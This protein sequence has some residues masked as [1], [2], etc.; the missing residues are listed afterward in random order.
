MSKRFKAI[1]VD[2]EQRAI[3]ILKH[4]LDEHEEI[5]IAGTAKKVDEAI[6][7]I[8]EHQ[9]DLVFL[10][11]KMPGKSGFE[12][13]HELT[14]LQLNTT[15]IFTTAY[16]QYGIEAIRHEAFD[17]LLKPIDPVELKKALTRFRNSRR[18]L[19]NEEENHEK[20]A[21][22]LPDKVRFKT[23]TGSVYLH[24]AEIIY[25]IADGNYSEIITSDQR[26]VVSVNLSRVHE[27]LDDDSFFRASRSLLI[28]LR[29]L[30]QIDRKKRMCVLV[31]EGNRYELTLPIDYIRKL[32][33]LQ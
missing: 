9:P 24:P 26:T 19:E 17:Y 14:Q 31:D 10:D 23:R 28:N 33:S 3:D 1:V 6:P 13:I 5:E 2:D 25:I 8:L 22:D 7:I 27:K 12:L 11:I 15:I 30:S 29:Y 18:W 32:E 20:P 16:S 21:T 4:L